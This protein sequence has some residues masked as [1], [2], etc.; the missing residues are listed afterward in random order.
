MPITAPHDLGS[1]QG[2]PAAL[3][4]SVCRKRGPGYCLIPAIRDGSSTAVWPG[5]P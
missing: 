2:R 4:W 5:G 3:A 1:S